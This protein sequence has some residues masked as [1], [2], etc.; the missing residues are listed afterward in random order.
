MKLQG[1]Y[2]FDISRERLWDTLMDP[3]A[4]R[5]CV[6]GVRSFTVLAPDRYEIEVAVRVGVVSGS[7]KA[8]L[9]V[10]EQTAPV[11]YRMVVQGSGARTNVKGEGGV[12]LTAEDDGTTTLTFDGDVQ[13]TGVLARA[14]Q[15]L[16]SSV[17]KTQIDRF[18]QCLNSKAAGT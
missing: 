11:S 8:T 5:G 4:V 16:M 1:S 14:G 17:A 6:P 12:A 18:F 15:R 10:V 13:V 7:Y 3:A 2:R 9:E